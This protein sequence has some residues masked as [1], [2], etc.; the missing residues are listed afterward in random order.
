[1]DA[2]LRSQGF[3]EDGADGLVA[4]VYLGYGLSHPLGR[5]GAPA[6]PEPCPLPAA[7]AE[8]RQVTQCYKVHSRLSATG[9][10]QVTQ[11]YKVGTPFRIGAWERSWSEAEYA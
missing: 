9:T 2:F 4:D 1:M 8:I 3:F 7:A 10:E 5:S 11:C 6:P